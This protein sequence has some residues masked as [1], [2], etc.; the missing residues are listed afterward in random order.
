MEKWYRMNYQPNSPLGENGKRVTACAEHIALSKDAAKEGMVLLKNSGDLLPFQKGTRLALFGKGTFDYVKGGGGSG[1]VYTEHVT[2]LYEGFKALEDCVSV[3]ETLA[4][5][6]RECVQEQYKE[7]IAPGMT[8]EPELPDELCRR[9]K[10]FADVAVISLCRFSGEGW[11]RGYKGDMDLLLEEQL[12]VVG[13]DRSVYEDGDFYLSHAERAMIEKV[14]N[15]FSKIV[16]VLN[17]GGMVATEWLAKDGRIQSVLMA[18]QGGMEGGRAAAELLCGIGNPSGKLTDTFARRLEDY[19]STEG[20]HDSFEHVDYTEDIYVGY[21]YF[22]TLPEAAEKVVYPFGYGLS[23]TEFE[24]APVSAKEVNGQIVIRVNVT[25]TGDRDGKEV[26]Q[27]Y[28]Q[29]PQGRLGKPARSLVAYQKT[30][31]LRPGETQLVSLKFPVNSMASYDDL[32]KV[33]KSAWLLERGDYRFHVGTSVRDT[34]ELNYVYTVEDDTVTEQLSAKLVPSSLKCR[35]MSDG[36]FEQLPCGE[37]NDPDANGLAPLAKDASV[38]R[39][40]PGVRQVER[41]PLPKYDTRGYHKLIDVAEGK[42]DLDEFIVQLSDEQLAYLLSAQPSTGVCNTH[43]IGNISEFEVPAVMTADGPA[44]LRLR[45]QCGIYTTAF[46]CATLLACTWNPETVFQVGEAGAKEVKENNLGMWLTPGVNIHR[47]PMCGRNFE[48]YS[49]DPFL[50]GTMAA[51]MVKGI[52]SQHISASVKHFAFN[53]KENNRREIDSRVSERAAREIYLKVFEIIVKTAK[54]WYVMSAYNN[55]NGHRTAECRE[56]MTDILRGEWG[57][58]GMVSTDWR[59]YS[60]HYKEIK[61][62][63]DVKMGIG[64]PE[65]LLEAM[66]KGLLTREEMETSG[67]RILSVILKL[68]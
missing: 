17:V 13:R 20:F 54:P 65:R 39:R 49:E 43:G 38:I 2:N 15:Y 48:Y 16:V 55:V 34:M 53:N 59:A 68:D 50:A 30:R 1:D 37:P 66:E 11:D 14:E 28:V 4:D 18:W 9:A 25:N 33:A 58:E 23:Y 7:G 21:R 67:K 24:W 62:G 6:Y 26:V 12:L 45:P 22:E 64:Y 61:A 52:Q 27:A 42:I 60:E 46:P 57:F 56:L 40:L 44:G 41:I 19:P 63:T 35:L 8:V 47:N 36:S 3:E 51:E 10:A 32:G 5:Y 29:A 31:L